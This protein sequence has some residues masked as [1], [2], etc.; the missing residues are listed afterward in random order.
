MPQTHLSANRESNAASLEERVVV[1]GRQLRET[2]TAVLEAIPGAPD[3]P[4]EL[5]ATLGIDKVLSSRFLKAARHRDPMA[6]AHLAPG[7]E[8][9][10]RLLRAASSIR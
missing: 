5:A 7:P 3:R 10:R 1:V 9:M 6:V 4:Q 8:P 2:L